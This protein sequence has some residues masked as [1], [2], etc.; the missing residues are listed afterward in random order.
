LIDLIRQRLATYNAQNAL[1]EEQAT[2]EILQEVALYLLWR[3]GFFEVAAFQGGTSLRILHRLPRFSED[4]DFLLQQPNAA[5]D[6]GRYLKPMLA[7]FTEF[8]LESEVLDKSKMDRNIR[9]ALVKHDSI[10]N[11]LNLKF[12]RG[13]NTPTLKIKLEIDVNPPA[14]S[15]F[16]YTYLDFPL[17]FEVCHQDLPSNFALKIHALLCRPYLKGRD[18]YDFNWYIRQ[19]VRPNLA[20]LQS[21]LDQLG[22]WK[23]QHPILNMPWV[24]DQLQNKIATIDWKAATE[25]V[26]RFLGAAERD[27]LKLWS[28]RFFN[29][30]AAQLAARGES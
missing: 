5:F 29:A 4:L 26:E 27:S 8:G 9:A 10:G 1:E 16:A 20:H 17:D 21:A 7:G 18:W 14:G 23:G 19:N 12:N 13:R 25:D 2:K 11:Q 24:I 28:A 30:R 15:G 3:G 6:W 22:P